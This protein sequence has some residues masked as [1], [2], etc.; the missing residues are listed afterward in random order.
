MSNDYNLK[1]IWSSIL[2]IYSAIAEICKKHGLTFYVTGGN[3]L[4]AVRHKGFIPWDDDLDVSLPWEDYDRFW[5][6]AR[7]ELPEYWKEVGW[8]N[9]PEY[10]EIF[11]K[12]QETRKEVVDQVSLD[13]RLP[14]PHGIYVDVFPL[15]NCPV[16]RIER[17]KWK[18]SGWLLKL[19]A[20]IV[21]N[22]GNRQTI[23]SRLVGMFGW[24]FFWLYPSLVDNQTAMMLHERRARRYPHNDR[25]FCGWYVPRLYDVIVPIPSTFFNGV[26]FLPFESLEVPVPVDYLGYLKYKFGDYMKLPL[27]DKRV[28]THGDMKFAAWRLGPSGRDIRKKAMRKANV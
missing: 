27:E 22:R 14:L 6:Y 1:P 7:K 12:I 13:S 23:R 24:M 26:K 4:G 5:E 20:S 18:I 3:C 11:G 9:T 15:V 28:P 8:W 10:P 19:K 17:L 21:L 16:S 2:D 25:G